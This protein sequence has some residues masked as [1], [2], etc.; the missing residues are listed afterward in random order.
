MNRSLIATL[1]TAFIAA[2]SGCA[3]YLEA[4]HGLLALEAQAGAA[5]AGLEDAQH[6]RGEL[7]AKAGTVGRQRADLAAQ[8]AAL[9][10][11][12]ADADRALREAPA[13]AAVATPDRAALARLAALQARKQTLEAELARLAGR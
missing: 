5:Q 12:L 10:R 7:G 2:C 6:R 4:R 3:T 11:E 9:E 1:A 13:A 8:I